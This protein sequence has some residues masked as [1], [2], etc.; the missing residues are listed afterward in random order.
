[1]FTSTVPS[2]REMQILVQY[3]SNIVLQAKTLRYPPRYAQ[4]NA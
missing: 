1:M 4:R 2:D 3:S